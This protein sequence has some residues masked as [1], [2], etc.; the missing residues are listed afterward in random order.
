MIAII[1]GSGLTRLPEMNITHR[2][3]VRTPYGLPSSPLMMGKLGSH[4]IMFIARHGLNHTLSPHEINYRANIWALHSAKADHIISVA[5]V[6]GLNEAHEP[7]SLIVP[8]NIIDYTSGRACTFFEGSSQEVVHIDFTHPYDHELRLNILQHAEQQGTAVVSRGVYGCIQ[9][10]RLPTLAELKKY[11]RDGV[12]VIG[13]TGM[14]EAVLAREVDLP[15]AHLCG[16]IGIAGVNGQAD[17]SPDFRSRQTHQAIETIR[18][19]LVD[20]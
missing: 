1:G 17:N 11:R 9:G 18:R 6:A 19:L 7:G 12:D 15:Y 3:I 10:P 8:D 2:R 14:P 16:V 5:T 13:M 4:E 20:L